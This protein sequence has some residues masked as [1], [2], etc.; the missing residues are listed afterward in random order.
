MPRLVCKNN[1]DIWQQVYEHMR[2]IYLPVGAMLGFLICF[3]NIVALVVLRREYPH[4]R[5]LC[6]TIPIAFIYTLLI[7]PI[8]HRIYLCH[9]LEIECERSIDLHARQIIWF[10][11]SAI[12]F[13]S[14]FPQCV[15]PGCFDHFFHSHQLFHIC[16][17]A[18]TLFQMDAV[19]EDFF[20][21]ENIFRLRPAPT[22]VDVILPFA[23]IILGEVFSI[24][25]FL[26]LVRAKLAHEKIKMSDAD[27]NNNDPNNISDPKI[28]AECS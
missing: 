21:R 5:K 24:W 28:H 8:V 12:F 15:L 17:T 11:F 7:S 13:V 23:L 2:D 27:F 22:V 19:F 26:R 9:E 4:V 3:C 18:G 20:H 16:I 10:L 6:Q 1:C 25:T 14:H